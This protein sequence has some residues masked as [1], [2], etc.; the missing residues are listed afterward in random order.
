VAPVIEV[1][2][3]ALA[4]FMT[5]ERKSEPDHPRDLAKSVTVK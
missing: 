2:P 1:V 5:N 4:H 3:S